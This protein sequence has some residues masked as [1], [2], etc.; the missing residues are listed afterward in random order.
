M[1]EWSSVICMLVSKKE[2]IRLGINFLCMLIP[3][4]LAL[5]G[6]KLW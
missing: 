3:A 5:K 6:G 1:N 2:E 4:K